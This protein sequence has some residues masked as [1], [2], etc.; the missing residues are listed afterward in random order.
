MTRND[1]QKLYIGI[2]VV[3]IAVAV[4]VKV[5]GKPP[6]ETIREIKPIVGRIQATITSTATVQPQNRLE[7]KP[8]INGRI[9]EILVREGDMVKAGQTLAWL[10]STERAALL[11]A[12]RARGPEA[13]KYWEDVY[14]AT[15]LISPIDGD[16]I[17]SQAEPG[18]IVTSSEAVL[19]LSDRLIVQAQVDETDVGG[20]RVGQEVTISLDAY[21]QIKVNGKV[22]HIYY[23]SKIVNNVTI[24]QVDIVPESVPE[25]FRSGMTA[26]VNIAEKTKDNV[27]IVPLEAVKRTKDGACILVKESRGRKPVERKVE[28][29]IA[30]E[31][32]IEVVSGISAGD[33]L[34]V[35]SQKYSPASDAK[36]GTNPL[37][38]FRRRSGK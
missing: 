21:P 38:P 20:I 15:P 7:I 22:D 34:V 23:E 37:M 19:V 3:L 31:K 2:G 11:D 8:P 28:L 33:S 17:V 1:R 32:N 4:I 6:K 12:A 10:S 27:I 29:G 35:V 30:D 16:V 18:Q 13:M 9:D 14:K 5:S 36:S 26:T 24:Y 25:V